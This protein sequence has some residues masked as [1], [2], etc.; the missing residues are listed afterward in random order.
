MRRFLRVFFSPDDAGGA[1]AAGT[2]ADQGASTGTGADQ[3][4]PQVDYQKIQRMLDGTL[5]AKEDTALK[6]YFKQQGLSQD[7]AEQAMT[8]FKSQKAAAQPDI[9]AIQSQLAQAQ[10]AAQQAAIEKSATMVAVSLGVDANTIPYMLRMA[11]LSKAVGQDGMVSDE[12]IKAAFEEVLKAVPGLKPQA[13]SG[14]GFVQLGA[15]G[16]QGQQ[17]NAVD[18]ELDSIFGIKKK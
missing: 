5:A 2:G 8:A 6:N 13:N 10:A 4:A 15:T 1:G 18:A 14:T 9:T 17:G 16:N 12:A 7:E 11:D 3:G